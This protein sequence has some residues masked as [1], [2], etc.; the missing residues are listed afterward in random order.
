MAES[1]PA[2]VGP[3]ADE[4]ET[5]FRVAVI[6][7]VTQCFAVDGDEFVCQIG[8]DGAD[9]GGEAFDEGL[10]IED[11]EDSPESVVA[12]RTVGEFENATQPRFLE[13]CKALKV[14]EVVALG[15]AVSGMGEVLK[16]LH[17]TSLFATHSASLN[18]TV[19]SHKCGLYV[20]K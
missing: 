11:G 20:R 8:A 9:V 7:A 3:S 18:Q 2:A 12:G 17:A 14:V 19:V 13:F 16:R 5:A 1:K 4:V 6:K 10:G 15:P